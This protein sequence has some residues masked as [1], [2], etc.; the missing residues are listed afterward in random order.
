MNGIII[1]I[2]LIFILFIG[3]ALFTP[4]ILSLFI[5]YLI[6][7]VA[8]YYR[9]VMPWR[10]SWGAGAASF[11][12]AIASIGWFVYVFIMQIRPMFVVLATRLPEIQHRLYD[13][14]A[15]LAGQF[16]IELSIS[17]I[18]NIG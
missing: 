13:S 14:I 4:L 9:K 6:N 10:E 18:P 3:R 7:S 2:G 12:L 11:A 15:H 8:A 16:G 1:F 5:W 17:A